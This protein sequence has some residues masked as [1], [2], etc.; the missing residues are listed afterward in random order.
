[1]RV[2]KIK[3]KSVRQ[4]QIYTAESREHLNYSKRSMHITNTYCGLDKRVKGGILFFSA[5]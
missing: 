5:K 2:H 1:M 4:C 3:Y